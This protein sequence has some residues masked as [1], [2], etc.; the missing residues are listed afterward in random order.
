MVLRND[1]LAMFLSLSIF[2]VWYLHY[3][4]SL[5]YFLLLRNDMVATFSRALYLSHMVFTILCLSLVFSMTL[6]L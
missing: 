1:A 2:F 5:W 6:V 4:V 3:F